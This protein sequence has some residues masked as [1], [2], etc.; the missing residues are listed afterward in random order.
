MA[1]TNN[2]IS[3]ASLDFDTLK[4]NLKGFLTSQTAFKDYDYEGSNMNVL[5]DVLSYNSYLN[6]FYLNMAVSEAFLDSAQLRS[7]VSSH[8][9]DLNYTPRSYRSSEAMV[10]FLVPTSNAVTLTIPK[11]TSFTG[12]NINGN[13]TFTTDKTVILTSGNNTFSANLAVYEGSYSQDAFVIDYTNETQRFTLANSNIDTNSL[14][15]VISENDGQTVSE[16]LPASNLYGLNANSN[17]YFLQTDIDGRYQIVFGDDVLGRKPLNGAVATAEYRT[18]SGSDAN[19]IDTFAVEVDLGA[20]NSTR[21]LSGVTTTTISA[22][23]SGANAE[24]VESIRYNAP[25]HYQTQERAVT[26]QDYIDLIKANFPDI[27]SVNAYGGETL[28]GI[29]SVEYGKVYVSCSTYSGNPLSTTRKNEVAAFLRPRAALGIS[30]LLVDPDYTYITLLSKVHVDF[31]QTGL[32]PTQMHTLIIDTISAFN[33]NNLQVFGADFR[34][35]VLMTAIDNAD[36]SVISNETSPFMYKKFTGFSAS[37]P[38]ALTVDFHGNSIKPGSVISNQFSS[39]GQNYVFTDF[40]PGVNN[41]S[42][43]LFKLQKTTTSTTLNYSAVGKIDYTNGLITIGKTQF[44]YT[45]AGGLR[46]F[47]SPVNQDI[48]ST[49]NNIIEIDT[50]SG[51]SVSIVSG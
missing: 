17:V 10:N 3:L 39:S 26:T 25:R 28:S 37:T 27:E 51:L 42:G 35:S 43:S 31:N 44:D 11:G 8:A 50:G 46:I 6:A 33:T 29:G 21:V 48:Y 4:S 32:T 45:P 15:V 12:K 1:T 5:L 20:I 13:Y 16:F 23:T 38:L 14:V 22:S 36:I 49:R 47:A 19:G 2:S 40:I 41:S 34:T 18:C 30:P 7:S 9:K 24:S